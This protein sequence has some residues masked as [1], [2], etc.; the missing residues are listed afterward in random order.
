MGA[1]EVEEPAADHDEESAGEAVADEAAE[2]EPIEPAGAEP[3]TGLAEEPVDEPPADEETGD[4]SRGAGPD[5]PGWLGED[6]LPSGD[7]ALGWLAQLAA[8]REDELQAQMVAEGEAR[9][10]E[11]MGRA[12]PEGLPVELEVETVAV[13]DEVAEMLATEAESP[14][15][16]APVSGATAGE[17]SDEAAPEAEIVGTEVPAAEV[18]F[19]WTCI[20]TEGGP[21]SVGPVPEETTVATEVEEMLTQ[22]VVETTGTESAMTEEGLSESQPMLSDLDVLVVDSSVEAVPA[23]ICPVEDAEPVMGPDVVAVMTAEESEVGE[24]VTE[25]S[26]GSD[27]FA[28]ER[29]RVASNPRDYDTWLVLARGLWGV[30]E[31]EESMGAY[32]RLIQG[33]KQLSEVIEDLENLVS[34]SATVQVRRMLGDAYMKDGR[35]REALDVYRAAMNT[36]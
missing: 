11:I 31:R 4:E 33:G 18:A 32:D 5:I 3:I 7:E 29:L 19:G 25:I 16:S 36:L 14:V 15:E 26:S 21:V 9:M 20:G 8:G 13:S 10:T 34:Q 22:P 30:G 1:V 24:E 23:E 35:L 12:E 2:E 28:D 17:V 6:Q 27:E